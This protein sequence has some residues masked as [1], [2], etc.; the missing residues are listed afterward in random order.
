[1]KTRNYHRLRKPD[2]LILL[3]LLVGLGVVVTTTAQAE[4]GVV[5]E[6][7]GSLQEARAQLAFHPVKG[8]AERLNIH[9]LNNALDRPVVSQLLVKRR[10][11]MGKPFG[12]KGP[13]LNMSLRP[14][15]RATAMESGDS[16]I[17]ALS[18]DRPDIYF[19]LR[20]SW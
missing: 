6:P 10:M 19:S 7:A 20:R 13:Q 8:L 3:A 9:W 17:G 1:M 5:M 4:S 16:G 12:E 18:S 15:M 2:P 14:Q 11:G